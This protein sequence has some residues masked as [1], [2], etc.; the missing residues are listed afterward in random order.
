MS[1]RVIPPKNYIILIGLIVLVIC[2]CFATYNLYNIYEDNK[3]SESP[4]GNKQL[5]YEELKNATKDM[6]ADTF[7]V[8]SYTQNREVYN[9]EKNIKKL[10]T[11]RN[12]ID[13][14][15]Y[16]DITEYK[17]NLELPKEM[18]SI[19]KLSGNLEIKKFPALVYYVN[20]SP[21]YVKDSVDHLLNSGDF[22]QAIEMY[23]LAS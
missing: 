10:L 21:V 11:K 1:K 8:I 12:L 19:L 5:L 7:L 15:L 18:N 9:N 14:V 22:E 4:L 2:A 23:E 20:G 6:E 3:I 13:N 16:L 17:D